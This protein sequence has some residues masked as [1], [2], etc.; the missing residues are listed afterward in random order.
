MIQ[1]EVIEDLQSICRLKCQSGRISDVPE[2]GIN[3][4]TAPIFKSTSIVLYIL[5]FTGVVFSKPR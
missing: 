3:C 2:A 1:I 4:K 5:Y